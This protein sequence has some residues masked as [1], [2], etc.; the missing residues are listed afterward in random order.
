MPS[1]VWTGTISFGLVAV[2]VRMVGAARDLDIH[3]HQ[4]DARSG[5]R[6]SNRRVAERDGQDVAWDQ[7]A[8]GYELDGRMVVLTDDELASAAPERT[9]M[10]EIEEFVD[11]TEIDPA[12]LDGAYFLLPGSDS[13][14]VTRAYRL[15]RDAMS[16]SGRMAIGRVVLRA[17]E[18]LAAVHERDQLLALST[19][20]YAD[21]IRDVSELDAIPPTDEW[22]PK[23]GELNTA[24]ELI[25]SMT[26]DFDPASYE[27]RDRTRLLELINSRRARRAKRAPTEEPPAQR[28]GS[29]PPDL[30]AAL[31][32]SL[33]RAKRPQ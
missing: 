24:V 1:T 18:Y 33:D 26:R 3:F 21:E 16:S 29:P 25:E 30:M 32:D 11:Q 8:R 12:Q 7:L 31:R 5:E 13:A 4:V 14:G 28:D 9:Q 15:L 27:D 19:M 6:I 22:V 17:N 2:P 20:L 23:R 10:I